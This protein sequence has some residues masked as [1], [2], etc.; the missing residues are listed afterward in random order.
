MFQMSDYRKLGLKGLSPQVR[1]WLRV[2]KNGPVHLVHGKCW[3]WLGATYP[4][5]RGYI[6]VSGKRLYAYVLSWLIHSRSPIPT[7]VKVCHKCDN[8]NCVNPGHLWLGTQA[9]NLADCRNKGRANNKA[10]GRKGTEHHKCRLTDEEA[11]FIR[12]HN[13]PGKRGNTKELATR[14]QI[15]T[16]HVRQIARGDQWL[17]LL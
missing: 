1:F 11:L 14:F 7:G 4:T 17:H 8:P 5:G 2:D 9:E 13:V 16:T 12:K 15:T 3:K 6:D 10:R